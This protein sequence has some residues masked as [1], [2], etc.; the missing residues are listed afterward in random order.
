MPGLPHRSPALGAV[1]GD[2]TKV[3]LHHMANEGNRADP[4]TDG[5]GR[6]DDTDQHAQWGIGRS[7]REYP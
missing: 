4:G 3:G 6:G 5:S 7:I 2:D 1:H